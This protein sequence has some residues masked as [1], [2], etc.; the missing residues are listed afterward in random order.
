MSHFWGGPGSRQ[1]P[2]SPFL[3][4]PPPSGVHWGL[5]SAPSRPRPTDAPQ[6]HGAGRD[7]NHERRALPCPAGK[8][9]AKW[10]RIPAPQQPMLSRFPSVKSTL[11]P[12]HAPDQAN[13]TDTVDDDGRCRLQYVGVLLRILA[14]FCRSLE[15]NL[16]RTSIVRSE[17]CLL[18][19][20]AWVEKAVMSSH[21]LTG[22]G[23]RCWTKDM[24]L[25]S[26]SNLSNAK[27]CLKAVRTWVQNPDVT[28]TLGRWLGVFDPRRGRL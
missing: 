9:G 10:V 13:G 11:V 22:A 19:Q 21:A 18:R 23:T 1:D 4:T 26:G 27:S 12:I 6:F 28:E 8:H 3:G 24:Q 15:E 16:R 7:G 20:E 2:V 25:P 5:T 14:G 17:F